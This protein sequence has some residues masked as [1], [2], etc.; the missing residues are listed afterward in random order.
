MQDPPVGHDAVAGGDDDAGR[1]RQL[2]AQAGE[3]LCKRRDDL[4]ENRADDQR[5]DHDDRD[6]VDHRG[7][8][9]PLQLDRLLDV[10]RQPLENGVEDA[11]RLA[12]RDH[13][14]VERVEGLRVLLHRVGE[15]R[16]R[17]DV[18]AGLEDDPRE[19]LVRLLL[20]EDVQTLHQ[21]QAGV[22]H[23]RELAR[24]DRQVLGR[25]LDPALLRRLGL[26]L[27]LPPDGVDLGD[28][29][30]VAPQRGDRRIHRVRDALAAH[31]LSGAGPSCIGKC[32][33]MG[34]SIQ[35][36]VSS[37]QL[38]VPQL[39]PPW[40]RPRRWPDELETGCTGD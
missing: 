35:F 37:C 24:E 20:A 19:S 2:G 16:A 10:G 14:R 15:R 11:A 38:P 1:E 31:R 6:R 12:G 36:P 32:G 22:D 29:D 28:L 30:V 25:D 26:G 5:G 13:V 23:D 27:G 4:P 39:S 21:R 3:Q 8:H 7:L 40:Q 34:P 33:H 9:F 17:F 18:F